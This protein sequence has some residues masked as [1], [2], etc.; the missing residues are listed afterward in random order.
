M[1]VYKCPHCNELTVEEIVLDNLSAKTHTHYYCNCKK[2]ISKKLYKKKPIDVTL[3]RV[4][5]EHEALTKTLEYQMDHLPKRLGAMN[6]ELIKSVFVPNNKS[7]IELD[8][9]YLLTIK[10]QNPE[11][12]VNDFVNF[13]HKAQTYGANPIKDQI[14]LVAYNTKENNQWIKRGNAIFSY[15]FY[16][17]KAKNDPDFLGFSTKEEIGDYFNPEN[18]KIIKQLKSTATIKFKSKRDPLE[19]TAWYPEFVKRNKDGRPSQNW[20]NPYMMLS[21]CALCNALKQAFPDTLGGMTSEFDKDG[22]ENKEVDLSGVENVVEAETISTSND[23]KNNDNKNV[24]EKKE[25]AK[26]SNV[27]ETE[28]VSKEKLDIPESVVNKDN[29]VQIPKYVSEAQLKRLFAIIANSDK[30]WTVDKA[31][32]FINM[33]FKISDK[34]DLQQNQY[35]WICEKIEKMSPSQLGHEYAKSVK[36]NRIN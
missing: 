8:V 16:I 29:Q 33:I 1:S 21:K 14:Y 35:K 9:T 22:I 19:Y 25:T 11:I 24:E 20:K 10:A 12:P 17:S 27:V 30:G 28:V 18:G 2:Q 34:K 5:K 3:E 15:H 31:D 36:E 32:E 23:N 26:Q 4:V 13:I 6:A 7:K